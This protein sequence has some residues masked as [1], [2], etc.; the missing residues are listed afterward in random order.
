MQFLLVGG[1]WLGSVKPDMNM[2]LK[3]ILSK[4]KTLENSGKTIK[5]KVGKK[6]LRAKLILAIFDLSYPK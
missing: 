4:I 5:T 1:L 3:P 2:I 6:K